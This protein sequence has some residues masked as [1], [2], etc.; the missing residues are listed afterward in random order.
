M[1]FLPRF[2]FKL[3]LQFVKESSDT[4]FVTNIQTL[5]KNCEEVHDKLHPKSD[6]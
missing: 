1:Q 5:K 6:L 4:L 3:A 2:Q